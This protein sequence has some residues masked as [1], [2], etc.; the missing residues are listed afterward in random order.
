LAPV[1]RKF[2]WRRD[3]EAVLQFQ[4]EIYE[5]NF[6]GLCVDKRFLSDYA[7]QL[8][9]ATRNA[10]QRLWVLD[11][12]GRTCGFLWAALITTMI[13]ECVG[14]IKNIYV[15]PEWREQ[16][17]GQQLIATAE[18]WFGSEGVK[19]AALDASVGN[20]AAQALYERMGY[21]VTRLRMEKSLTNIGRREPD[22]ARGD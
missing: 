18:Q 16:G 19:K 4:Y 9:Q 17:Y 3:K 7:R 11:E 22:N 5:R 1:I 15:A 8:Q 12:S 2:N 14:Y 13:D 6:P 21:R 20:E 10:A